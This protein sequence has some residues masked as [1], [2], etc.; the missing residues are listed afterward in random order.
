M[1]KCSTCVPAAGRVVSIANSF[2]CGHCD[3]S[4]S[5]HYLHS[6]HAAVLPPPGVL[7]GGG[8]CIH[9]MRATGATGVGVPLENL[10]MGRAGQGTGVIGRNMG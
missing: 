10:D 5:L 1:C 4:R 2:E 3:T 7:V 6:V 8:A 9:D